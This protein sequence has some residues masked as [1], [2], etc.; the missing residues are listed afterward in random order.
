MQ[1]HNNPQQSTTVLRILEPHLPWRRL[2][3]GTGGSTDWYRVDAPG[4]EPAL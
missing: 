1:F 4:R 3:S 2:N